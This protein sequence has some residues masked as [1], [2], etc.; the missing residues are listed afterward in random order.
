[1]TFFSH[2]RHSHPLCLPRDRLSTVLR[3]FSHK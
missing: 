3:K 2:R 1:M